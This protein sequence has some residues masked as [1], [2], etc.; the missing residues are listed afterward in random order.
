MLA[1]VAIFVV[2]AVITI[3]FGYLTY[4]AIRASRMWVKIVGGLPAAVFTL[5]FAAV[6]VTAAI[7]LT[8]IYGTVNPPIPANLKIDGTP[9]QL[10]RGQYI[11]NVS[12][13][14]C[15][16]SVPEDRKSPLTG[17][18]DF[19]REIPVPIGSMIVSN[20]ASDGQIK[21]YTDAQLFRAIRHGVRRDGL[22]LTS[23]PLLAIREYSDDDVKSIIAYLRSQP[24]AR[25]NKEGGDQLNFVA[26]M[27]IGAGMFPSYAPA[28]E[29]VA[30]IPQ[31]ITAAYGKYVGTL[32]D[33]RAC[34]GPNMTGT[35]DSNLGPGAPNPRP[36]V[37]TLTVDQFRRTL[38]TGKRPNGTDLKM[39]WQNAAQMTDDD[40]A[41]LY[42]YL[43]AQP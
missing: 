7:G 21:D 31:G 20:I 22:P 30:S 2:L 32:G 42:A 27:L 24:P 5:V 28:Q 25:S 35:P 26:V 4:R 9:A 33:C 18:A 15:H 19:A 8:K 12:C 1:N 37:A 38:K 41:A 10:A 29:S 17:G 40:L 14:G 11:V 13:A 34:H 39:P 6:T 16:A 23:M 43:R 3:G 36:F